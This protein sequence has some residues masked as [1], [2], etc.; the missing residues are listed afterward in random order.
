MSAK[1]SGCK[2]SPHKRTRLFQNLCNSA[3]NLVCSWWFFKRAL[4]GEQWQLTGSHT[5]RH[6]VMIALGECAWQLFHNYFNQIHIQ[7]TL[8]YCPM[9]QLQQW[10]PSQSWWGKESQVLFMRRREM[11]KV[12]QKRNR[13]CKYKKKEIGKQGRSGWVKEEVQWVLQTSSTVAS[14]PVVERTSSKHG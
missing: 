2:K 10:S 7:R 12:R 11:G 3:A 8:I 9:R 14:S 13:P 5:A 1:G 4:V 6:P